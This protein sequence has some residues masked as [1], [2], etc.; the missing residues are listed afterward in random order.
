[1]NYQHKLAAA[2]L[3]AA[4]AGVVSAQGLTRAQVEA[5]TMQAIRNGDI[6]APGDAGLTYRQEDPAAYPAQPA[7]PP[8]KTR[9]QVKAE[10]MTAIRN[11]D[12]LAPG[13]AGETLAQEYPAEYPAKPIVVGKT[14]AEA[15]EERDIAVRDGD[16]LA[17]GEAGMTLAQEEP[18]MY[19]AQRAADA[20]I[21]A[22]LQAQE[23]ARE[24]AQAA[25]LN[26]TLQPAQ[27][28]ATMPGIAAQ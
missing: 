20:P 14:R 22:K 18:A 2:V 23:A 27:S 5:Q 17:P 11:G 3:L 1:M 16:I 13:D 19:A 10:T 25:L 8:G 9:A 12:I 26:G 6:M 4:V 15:R 7:P 21:L 28:A 24:A